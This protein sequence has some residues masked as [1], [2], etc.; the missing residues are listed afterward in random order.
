MCATLSME[1]TVPRAP[2]SDVANLLTEVRALEM[3]ANEADVGPNRLQDY[4]ALA[5][6]LLILVSD[7]E[8]YQ[9]LHPT[10]GYEEPEMLS[11]RRRMREVAARL[12][13]LT[14]ED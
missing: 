3:L 1:E 7:I 11:L 2:R 9:A 8:E 5:S 14:L 4:W 6:D 13:E 10:A 12:A